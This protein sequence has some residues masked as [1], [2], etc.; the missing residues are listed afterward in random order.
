MLWKYVRYMQTLKKMKVR[1][2]WPNKKM[3]QLLLLHDDARLHTA[4]STREAIAPPA[5]RRQTAHCSEHTRGNCSNGVHFFTYLSL[6]SRFSTIWLPSFFVREGRTPRT[7]FCGR[8]GEKQFAWRPSTLQQNFTRPKYRVP[9]KSDKILKFICP[10]IASI[11]LKYNQQYATFSRS[12][13]FYKLLYMFQAVPPRIIR[14]TKLYIQRQV[15]WNR[16]CCLL[17]SWM[18]WNWV[19]SHPRCMYNFV[20]LMMGGGTAWNM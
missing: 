17:L 13:Y 12:V 16:Y 15:L 18:G 9:R 3:S 14:S 6:Q 19:T 4:L 20:L 8:R 2:V 11:S 5:R 1:W 7:P 10:Y